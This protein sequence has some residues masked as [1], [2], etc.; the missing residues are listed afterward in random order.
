MR[1][2]ILQR[3]SGFQ[4]VFGAIYG[5][6]RGFPAGFEGITG[7]GDFGG[8]FSQM[9]YSG[10]EGVTGGFQSYCWKVQR[11]SNGFLRRYRE[12]EDVTLIGGLQSAIQSVKAM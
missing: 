4:G 8:A 9:R 11:V 10:L 1:Y 7:T 3:Y 5:R 12:F 6:F 2:S